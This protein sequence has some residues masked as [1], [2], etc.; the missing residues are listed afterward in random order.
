MK[1][2]YSFLLLLLVLSGFFENLQ[3]AKPPGFLHTTRVIV[4]PKSGTAKLGILAPVLPQNEVYRNSLPQNEVYK[5]VLPHNEVLTSSEVSNLT[6]SGVFNFF[7]PPNEVF[8]M[9]A[10]KCQLFN[11]VKTPL[12]MGLNLGVIS[13]R[14]LMSTLIHGGEKLGWAIRILLE[15]F[16]HIL[17]M[18]TWSLSENLASVQLRCKLTGLLLK[19]CFFPKHDFAICLHKLYH[20][21]QNLYFQ[22]LGVFTADKNI[23]QTP[24]K[25]QFKK[26]NQFQFYG[27]GKALVFASD[28]LF[29]YTSIALPEQQ[30]QFLQCVKRD[31]KQNNVL[32][33]GEI[34]CSVPLNVLA[35]KLT[36]VAAKKLAVLHDMYM[37]SK[38]LLKNAQILLEEH[39]CQTCDDI[40]AVFKPYK[41]ASNAV[42]QKTWYQEKCQKTC[43]V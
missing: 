16:Q 27:G 26:S 39:K 19:Q 5:I 38:I 4:Y 1:L 17:K 9:V 22:H 25:E 2:C 40:L 34:F 43:K 18:Y 8:K 41:V 31:N 24:V 32:S 6:L 30:Y 37:P 12:K 23:C 21:H 15:C 28:E 7:L 20:G 42:H 10:S 14:Y 11:N 33:E 36:L 13:S 35:P 29:L 3:H